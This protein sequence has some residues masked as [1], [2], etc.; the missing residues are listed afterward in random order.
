MTSTQIKLAS[1]IVKQYTKKYQNTDIIDMLQ[2]SALVND[3]ISTYGED[4]VSNNI[5]EIIEDVHDSIDAGYS[6]L[7]IFNFPNNKKIKQQETAKNSQKNWE[8]NCEKKDCCDT[9]NN[10]IKK[11]CSCN[12]KTWVSDSE[13]SKT[14]KFLVPGVEKK[15]IQLVVTEEGKLKLTLK[16]VVIESAFVNPDMKIEIDVNDD[17]LDIDSMKASL[18]LGILTVEIPKYKKIDKTKYVDIL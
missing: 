10:E 14:I 13:T 11:Q 6:F 2:V 4:Y 16:D 17:L 18:N 3:A 7:D 9:T 1:N 5:D 8:N 12:K 15:N